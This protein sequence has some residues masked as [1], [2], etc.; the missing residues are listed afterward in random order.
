MSR[1]ALLIQAAKEELARTQLLAAPLRSPRSVWYPWASSCS[2][3]LR[4]VAAAW[5]RARTLALALLIPILPRI[6]ANRAL[7]GLASFLEISSI[8][9]FLPAP[10]LPF[11]CLAPLSLCFSNPGVGE[12]ARRSRALRP[13]P[14]EPVVLAWPPAQRRGKHGATAGRAGVLLPAEPSLAREDVLQ[15]RSASTAPVP[16]PLSLL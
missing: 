12:G 13:L 9:C 7:K 16:L 11:P 14:K 10:S 6:S 4:G 5:G 1:N 8:S 3:G 15:M 2:P